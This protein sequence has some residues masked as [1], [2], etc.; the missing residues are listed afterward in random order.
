M[1]AALTGMFTVEQSAERC[2]QQRRLRSVGGFGV[3]FD[4]GFGFGYDLML[5]RRSRS[6][7][8]GCCCCC[9]CWS[10]SLYLRKIMDGVCVCLNT[11]A[12]VCVQLL[13]KLL[14]MSDKCAQATAARS[15]CAHIPLLPAPLPP[16]SISL[17]LY[18]SLPRSATSSLRKCCAKD[19]TGRRI[20]WG[21]LLMTL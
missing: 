19:D 16:L 9:C 21:S 18:L 11:R 8:L 17:T 12:C 13:G 1:K 3:G 20:E 5:L 15:T 2:W 10:M 7:C 4:F 6:R 14:L